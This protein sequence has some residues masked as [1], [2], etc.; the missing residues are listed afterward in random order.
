MNIVQSADRAFIDGVFDFIAHYVQKVNS[1]AICF[2]M[3]VDPG[4][5]FLDIIGPNDLAYVLAVFK[6]GNHMSY[7]G[8]GHSNARRGR[9]REE[10]E[11]ALLK[12]EW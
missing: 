5:S 6:N 10:G 3:K 2:A 7:V 8:S 11:A 12:W 1:D 4:T 9:S